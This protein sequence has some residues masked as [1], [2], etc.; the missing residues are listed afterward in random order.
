MD[1]TA[2]ERWAEITAA[3]RSPALRIELLRRFVRDHPD[4]GPAWALLGG[5]LGDLSQFGEAEVALH[6][7]MDLARPR[8]A[9]YIASDLG[10]LFRHKGDYGAAEQW[11]RR[12]IDLSPDDAQGYIYLGALLARAGRL[13]EAEEVHRR[14]TAC[15]AGC[16]DEAYHNLGLVLRALGRYAE[17]GDCFDKALDIDPHY[18]DARAARRDVQKAKTLVN[19]DRPAAADPSADLPT[20]DRSR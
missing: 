6:R 19:A 17:A 13:S 3:A 12:A 5:A 16:V 20:E 9:T 11:F 2:T 8:M 7:A 15:V 4:H 18:R 1:Q 14:G 10:T